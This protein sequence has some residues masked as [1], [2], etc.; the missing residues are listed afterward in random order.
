MKQFTIA[1]ALASL[2]SAA[3]IQIDAAIGYF[4]GKPPGKPDKNPDLD[5]RDFDCNN[6]MYGC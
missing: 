2:T 5:E 6:R 4:D 1:L 3:T